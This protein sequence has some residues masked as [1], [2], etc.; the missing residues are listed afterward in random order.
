MARRDTGHPVFHGCYDWHSAVHGHWAL[1]RI[2]RA[3]GRHAREAAWVVASLGRE[4]LASEQ[5]DL[6][7]DVAFEMPYG[8]AWFLRLAIEHAA[9]SRATGGDDAARLAPMADRVA[10]S[11]MAHCELRRDGPATREYASLAWALTQLHAYLSM[12]GDVALLRRTRKIIAEDF[13]AS[14]STLS[15]AL[16]RTRPDFFSPFASWAHLVATTTDAA[17]LARFLERHPIADA[18]LAPPPQLG[19]AHHLGLP[20]SRAW[21]FASLARLAPRADRPRFSAAHDA[22][23]RAGLAVLDR[24]AGNYLAHDHWVPQFAVHALTEGNEC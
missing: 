4:G 6:E 8:R 16:D 9:W 20:W 22:H 5:A 13:V 12:R 17:T 11:L 10:R 7:R 19:P 14:D 24:H 23:L 18:D 15:L 2:A 1:M 3:T 21:A